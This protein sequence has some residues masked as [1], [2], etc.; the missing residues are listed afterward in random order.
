M[1][2]VEIRREGRE[3]KRRRDHAGILTVDNGGG[4][5]PGGGGRSLAWKK[6]VYKAS[7]HLR[8]SNVRKG[9]V[10][11]A[12]GKKEK[13]KHTQEHSQKGGM[14]EGGNYLN[15]FTLGVRGR[16]NEGKKGRHSRP[17]R[18]GSHGQGSDS[19]KKGK[20]PRI[21]SARSW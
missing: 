8:R 21:R 12:R 16:A 20:S 10:E 19:L 5:R 18:G 6:P 17:L 14:T 7:L 13:T 15:S 11:A 9:K 4:G 2:G 1:R 3:T